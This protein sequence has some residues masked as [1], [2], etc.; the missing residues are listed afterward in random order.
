MIVA[1]IRKGK[2]NYY[3]NL[4]Q[5]GDKFNYY[6]VYASNEVT[7]ILNKNQTISLFKNV[8]ESKLTFKEK[9]NDYDVYIDEAGNKRY[10]KDGK[11]DYFKLFINNGKPT[12]VYDDIE[13]KVQEAKDKFEF[14]RVVI[15]KGIVITEFV[16]SVF[17]ASVIIDSA[18]TKTRYSNVIEWGAHKIDNLKGELTAG[19][20]NSYITKTDDKNLDN[21]DRNYLANDNLFNDV[22]DYADPSRYYILR[23][24]MKDINVRYFDES[25]EEKNERGVVGYYSLER[26][27]T[28]NLKNDSEEVFDYAIGHEFIHLL[29][30]D[31]NYYYIREAC[32]EIMQYEY[33]NQDITAYVDQ[34]LRVY[35]LMEI[36]G[37]TPVIECNFKGDTSTFENTIISNLGEEDGNRLLELFKN[38]PCYNQDT[39]DDVNKEIDELLSKMYTNVYGSDIND[40]SLFKYLDVDHIKFKAYD[41]IYFNKNHELYNT[42]LE[43]CYTEREIIDADKL[44]NGDYL[45]YCEYRDEIDEETYKELKDKRYD[46]VRA[47]YECIDGYEYSMKDHNFVSEDGKEVYNE[48][49]AKERNIY[50]NAEYY[51]ISYE[52]YD[53]YQSLKDSASEYNYCL[54]RNKSDDSRVGFLDQ[55]ENG[56]DYVK[57]VDQYTDVIEPIGEKFSE[58]LGGKVVKEGTN[59]GQ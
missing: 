20:M 2:D 44:A 19:E 28:L 29:Q 59:K 12:I 8:F 24:K 56:N 55:D 47:V 15:N 6:V 37:P 43:V 1:N 4:E 35:K 3:V 27:N 40:D 25:D 13:Q 42:P 36:I 21:N 9:E 31:N 41:R 10:Y 34:V 51:H 23:K 5:N 39:I 16:G 46:I 30:D 32:A 53:T 54:V 58:Q 7:Y 26:I 33:Y 57:K 48:Q 45:F 11:E 49:E 50:T 38:S 14:V 52:K 22:L 17:L 18:I